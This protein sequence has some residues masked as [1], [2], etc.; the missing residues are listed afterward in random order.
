MTKLGTRKV[1]IKD[2][3]VMS[4]LAIL[5]V[6]LPL[7]RGF[8]YSNSYGSV[9]T[10]KLAQ[11]ADGLPHTTAVSEEVVEDMAFIEEI[12][13]KVSAWEIDKIEPYLAEETFSNTLDRQLDSV[14]DTLA[15]SLGGLENF[16]EPQPI[17][18]AD[19]PTD[20]D[21]DE[22]VVYEFV[23][24]YEAG[25][26]DINLVLAK[27]NGEPALYSFNINIQDTRQTL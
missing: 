13:P 7:T 20:A 1:L 12:F 27:D 22:L 19:M 5:L 11:S 21:G 15:T 16:T 2:I 26:A 9:A 18:I 24:Y 3:V 8:W 17:D 14:L 10:L 25:V 6:C 4:V 23:A